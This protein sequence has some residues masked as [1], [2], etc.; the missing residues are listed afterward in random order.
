MAFHTVVST[1]FM[2][3]IIVVTLV[4]IVFQTVVTVVMI[5]LTIVVTV[6]LMAFHTVVSTVLTALVG[7]HQ[8][9]SRDGA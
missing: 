6:V 1:V 9:E 3:L 7:F 4:L 2:A 8:E 5:A